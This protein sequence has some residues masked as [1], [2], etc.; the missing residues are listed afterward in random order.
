MLTWRLNQ[1]G[2]RIITGAD[3]L[4]IEA[5][6]VRISRFGQEEKL[7][8]DTVVIA[9]GV[10]PNHDLLDELEKGNMELYAIGDCDEPRRIHEAI[11]S[12]AEVGLRI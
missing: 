8:A 10:K 3:V 4:G 5:D 12:G 6:A 1:K 2:V 7:P 11:S 9:K